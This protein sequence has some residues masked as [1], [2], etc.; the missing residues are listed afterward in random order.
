MVLFAVCTTS[1]SLLEQLPPRHSSAYFELVNYRL[2][3]TKP[4]V[5]YFLSVIVLFFSA[6]V[7][8]LF[9]QAWQDELVQTGLNLA[10]KT[11]LMLPLKVAIFSHA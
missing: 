10:E 11:V 5:P 8:N 9:A 1:P 3:K 4:A 6:C 7:N 2:V